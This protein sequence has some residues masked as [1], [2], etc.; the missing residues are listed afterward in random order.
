MNDLIP[1]RLE[2]GSKFPVNARD[3]HE[4][5]KVETQFSHWI[6]RRI[7]EYGFIENIEYRVLVKIDYNP[8]RRSSYERIFSNHRNS[9]RTFPGR[10]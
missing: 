7:E 4:F 2:E 9:Q 10:K 8:T 3:L 6:Q 1:I 5:L